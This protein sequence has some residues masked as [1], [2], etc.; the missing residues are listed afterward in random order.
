[1]SLSIDTETIVAV[2]ALGEW[3]KVRRGSVG[4]DAFELHHYESSPETRKSC[5]GDGRGDPS[6]LYFMGSLYDKTEPERKSFWLN[7]GTGQ[8]RQVAENPAGCDGFCFVTP[9][10]SRKAFSL[11]ECKAFEYEED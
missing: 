11:V 7:E 1:M 5:E 6:T 2:Y 10:G 3:H 8:R 9:S 4:I